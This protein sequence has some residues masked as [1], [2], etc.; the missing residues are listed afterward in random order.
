M[1]YLLLSIIC[2]QER[3]P[4]FTPSLEALKRF[5]MLPSLPFHCAA[6]LNYF[7]EIY[8]KFI[9]VLRL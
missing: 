5:V 9:F 7:C 3:N 4:F 2:I 1:V 8:V 6:I